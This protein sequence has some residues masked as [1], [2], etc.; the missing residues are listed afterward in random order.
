MGIF[1]QISPFLKGLNDTNKMTLILLIF[2]R[3]RE[4]QSPRK[5]LIQDMIENP[6][7]NM[8]FLITKIRN[9]DSFSFGEVSGR[10]GPRVTRDVVDTCTPGP[11]RGAPFHMHV[12]AYLGMIY[13]V[14]TKTGSG[15]GAWPVSCPTRTTTSSRFFSRACAPELS[16]MSFSRWDN[17]L[18]KS[19]P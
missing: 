2:I 9:F 3:S 5:T 8:Q 7:K 11:Y 6:Q 14:W 10:F 13:R 1:I 12:A 17:F 15:P 16:L 19:E 4:H 18:L